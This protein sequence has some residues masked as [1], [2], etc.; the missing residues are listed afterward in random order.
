[1]SE[2]ARALARL[3]SQVDGA[4]EALRGARFA[5]FAELAECIDRARA[6]W[7]RYGRIEGDPEAVGE[8]RALRQSLDR[9]A[10]VL[11]H[12]A[13]VRRALTAIDPVH[14]AVYDH[15]GADVAGGRSL[16]HEEA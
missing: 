13:G 14:A 5:E 1:M 6:A 15:K 12:V 9:L 16:V 8:C 11:G 7:G 4:A 10:A 3:R 2:A